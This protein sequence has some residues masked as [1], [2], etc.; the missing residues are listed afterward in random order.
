[1]SNTQN[2]LRIHRKQ[3]Q[4]TQT[5]IAY[6]LN[7]SDNSPIS[8]IENGERLPSIETLLA[9]HLLFDSQLG[10]FFVVHRETVKHRVVSRIK[11]LVKQIEE[12][13]RT[14]RSQ[15]RIEFLLKTLAKL[16]ETLHDQYKQGN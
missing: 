9:Y 14:V 2:T 13:P 10:D 5:D 15:G 11:P 16:K 4:L 1:M 12:E 6:L 3:S 7:L 8:R